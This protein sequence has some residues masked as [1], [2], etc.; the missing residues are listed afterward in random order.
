M[1]AAVFLLLGRLR[2]VFLFFI[3]YFLDP[4]PSERSL[5]AVQHT[6]GMQGNKDY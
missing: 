3:F 5:N 6:V 1:A 4:Q 2:V